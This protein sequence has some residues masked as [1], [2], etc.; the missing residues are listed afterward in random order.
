MIGPHEYI[1]FR[2]EAVIQSADLAVPGESSDM[3]YEAIPAGDTEYWHVTTDEHGRERRTQLR[4]RRDVLG[5]GE[6]DA[7]H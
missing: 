6:S 1:E 5:P 3:L 4:L 7:R 2:A